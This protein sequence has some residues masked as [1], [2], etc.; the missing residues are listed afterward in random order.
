MS[1]NIAMKE[2]TFWNFWTIRILIQK[3]NWKIFSM[4]DSSKL[5]AKNTMK[6]CSIE[7]QSQDVCS[8]VDNLLKEVESVVKKKQEF[9]KRD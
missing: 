8:S 7:F 5:N 1:L 9:E 2:I 4:N 6:F 3:S